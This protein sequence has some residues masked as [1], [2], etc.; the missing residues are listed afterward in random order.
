MNIEN[1][2]KVS[3]CVVTYNQ[4][5]Y[6]AECLESLVNQ[7]TNFRYEI[8]VGEDCSTDGTRAIVQSYVEKHP[9]LI[10]PL[11]YKENVGA[12][13]NIK[14]VYKKA[15][16]KYIA[17]MDGDDIALPGKLQKQF[18][19]LEKNNDCVICA[20]QMK[21]INENDEVV[22]IDHVLHPQ[23]KYTRYDLYLIHALFRHSSKMFLN[24]IE[25]YIDSL[26]ENTLDIEL[27]ITQSKYGNIY[28]MNEYLGQY[29]ENVGVTF[30]NKFINPIIIDRVEYLYQSVDVNEFTSKQYLNIQKKYSDILLSYAFLCAKTIQDV[31]IFNAFVKKSTSVYKYSINQLIF[32]MGSLC[33]KLFFKLCS[34]KRN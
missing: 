33:P 12:V 20:H 18:E 29:R 27:H 7:V 4:E 25:N 28:L 31:N 1:D 3:V 32:I 17:H 5:N 2:I 34:F 30:K 14:Q 22:G 11:F 6:I 9:N 21:L 16:G 8:I 15:K 23:G 24:N 26:H 13:E 19:V 10:V